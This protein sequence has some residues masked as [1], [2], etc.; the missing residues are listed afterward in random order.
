MF[1]LLNLP[2]KGQRDGIIFGRGVYVDKNT[3]QSANVRALASA[4]QRSAN[5]IHEKACL[6][7]RA[8]AGDLFHG[9]GFDD[10]AR[11]IKALGFYGVPR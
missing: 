8:L 9:V 5:L 3:A 2:R 7:M 11:P 6:F 10:V 4:L 1:R